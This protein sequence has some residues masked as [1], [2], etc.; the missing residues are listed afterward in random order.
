M[1]LRRTAQY[2]FIFIVLL[3][4][5]VGCTRT[6]PIYNVADR[7]TEFGRDDVELSDM[8]RAI[9]RAGTDLGWQ[10][11]TREP[12]HVV[13]TL[14]VRDHRA[15]VDVE[16]DLDSFSIRYRD[17]ENLDYSGGEIHSNYN[18]WIQNLENGITRELLAL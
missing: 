5:A 16:Y 9:V 14:L 12:G 10:M 13:G 1:T 18:G 15:E 7:S 11:R 8:T 17:S 3:L 2:T 4:L 6:A